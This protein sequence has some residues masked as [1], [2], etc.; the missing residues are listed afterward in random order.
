MRAVVTRRRF[1]GIL[2]SAFAWCVA[3]AMGQWDTS[4]ERKRG[5]RG[6]RR[7]RDDDEYALP[8]ELAEF[9]LLSLVLGRVSDR[10]VTVSA[11]AK[12]PME[13]FCE[14]GT[15]SGHY[16]HTTN[17]VALPAGAPVELVFDNLRPNT[18]YFYQAQW[19]KPGEAGFRARPE[20]RFHTQRAAGS[21]FT[22]D[23]QGDSHPERPQMSDPDLYA[24]TLLNAASDRPDFHICMGDDFS[25]ARVRDVNFDTVARRYTLQRPFLGLIAQSAPIFLVNG[26][27]EQASLFN[28]NQSDV[29]HDVAVL[30][31]TARNRYF[32]T[33]APDGFYSGDTEPLESIGLRKD[34]CAWTWGD[35]LFV[36]LDCYWH[37]PVLV[38]SGFHEEEGGGGKNGHAGHRDRDWWGITLGDAQYQWFKRT[39]EQSTAKYKFVFAHH[40]LGTG[41]G[42]I[43]ECDLYEWGGRNKRGE[44]EFGQ[45]RPGWDM[46]VHQLMA[47]HGVTIFFQGHDHLYVRQERDGV[48]YQEV[49][50]P[51]DQGYVAYNEDRYE[52]GVKLPNSGHLRVTVS[53]E[54]VKVDYVR[55]Y[56]PKDETDQ[57]KTGEIAHSYTIPS[58]RGR[59]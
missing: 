43:D 56:L 8:P 28:Y 19:R 42:G 39:L 2:A 44:A 41:R 45:C 38:D 13:A 18:E 12:E 5:G 47:R 31:Q 58:R 49:P 26:N 27:H 32:P 46:P 23:V 48:V 1:L 53:P 30:A 10:S 35:A 55:C 21:T 15:A 9:D 7:Q 11:L 3:P 22:F 24:R 51:A 57:R 36:I 40:V 33:P 4:D 52:S 25:V 20:C 17:V 54:Q 59:A 34:Y 29:R 50:M 16:A 37:S 6:G 14:Y